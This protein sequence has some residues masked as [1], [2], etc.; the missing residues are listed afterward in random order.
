MS[1]VDASVVIEHLA[2]QA[3]DDEIAA[4]TDVPA[5]PT[6]LLVEVTH[7]LRNLARRRH[8]TDADAERLR[9]LLAVL[10]IDL[11]PDAALL[12]GA[13]ALRHRCSTYDALYV[14]LAQALDR[15]LLTRDARLARA[16]DGVVDVRCPG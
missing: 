5:A 16:V 11:H 12:D 9:D 10:T 1:V 8:I 4:I 15:P 2:G 3:T 14:T 13:W 7:V 6:L